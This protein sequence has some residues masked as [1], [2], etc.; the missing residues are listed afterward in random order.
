MKYGLIPE[1]VGRLPIVAT[2]DEA[3]IDTLKKIFVEPKNSILKQFSKIFEMENVKL[4]FTEAAIGAIAEEA[5]KRESGARG[6]RAVVEDI[7]M[8]LM[9]QIPSREDISEVVVTEEA[10]RN[11]ESSLIILKPKEKIA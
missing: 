1:F 7:M 5:I 4:K 3:D 6:L 8:D 9:Y 2:L 11:R 10:I